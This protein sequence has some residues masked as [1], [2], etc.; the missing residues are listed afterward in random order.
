MAPLIGF[1]RKYGSKFPGQQN[2]TETT[3][4]KLRVFFSDNHPSWAY[5][6]ILP[7]FVSR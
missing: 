3:P 7:V 2:W 4:E 1:R 5:I 6:E